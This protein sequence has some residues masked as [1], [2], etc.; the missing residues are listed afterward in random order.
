MTADPGG[1]A[2]VAL[3]THMGL[4]DMLLSQGLVG[5][6]CERRGRVALVCC[7][8][9][10]GT[11]GT[12]FEHLGDRVALV[13][14]EEAHAISPAF[15]AGPGRLAALER[16]GYEI[17]ELG[18]HSGGAAW[19]ALDP[20]WSRA[21][22]RQAGVDPDLVTAGFVLPA[23]RRGQAARV[24]AAAREIA[25]GRKIVLVHDDRSRPLRAPAPGPDE[26][27]LH[28]DDPRIRS[29]NLFDYV[30]LLAAAH[31]LHALESCFALLVDLAGLRTPM[32]IHAYARDPHAV[33]QYQRP[34]TV[35]AAVLRSPPTST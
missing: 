24:L 22:Y 34:T 12:L 30:D 7:R 27:V 13:P 2:G 10:L 11:L 1:R 29:D 26:V 14:V 6:L 5:A 33:L 31:H 17:L 16:M 21:L 23:G 25:G 35:V 3:L 19:R 8:K 4:G 9:Y 15:G 28:V 18:F 32:T 20:L